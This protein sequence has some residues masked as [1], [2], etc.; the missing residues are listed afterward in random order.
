[1]FS[2]KTNY[3][4]KL[5]EKKHN[6]RNKLNSLL[7]S[8]S[9][10]Q[11]IFETLKLQKLNELKNKT[12]RV[13]QIM[14]AIGE[15]FKIKNK[16]LKMIKADLISQNLTKINYKRSLLISKKLKDLDKLNEEFDEEFINRKYEHREYKGNN[17]DS[18]SDDFY[19]NSIS[20]H[21][22]NNNELD[23]TSEQRRIFKILFIKNEENDNKPFSDY[24]K[25]K[26]LKELKSNIEYVCGIKL[27]EENS[28]NKTQ[29][30]TKSANKES[31]Y[32]IPKR[33]P[34]FI[35]EKNKN[36]SF[37]PS[38]KYDKSKIFFERN[39]DKS[40]SKEDK[41]K[42][43]I[44]YNL[45]NY[46]SNNLH[47]NKNFFM[48]KNDISIIPIKKRKISETNKF[49]INEQEKLPIINRE[50]NDENKNKTLNIP[51]TPTKL[52]INNFSYNN[53]RNNSKI[54]IKNLKTENNITEQ[55][56]I[57]SI[58]KN[59]LK[60][61]YT[62]NS[63]MKFGLNIISSHLDIYKKKSKKK[64]EENEIDIAKI[65]KELN[66]NLVN[67]IIRES[68]I[69]VKNEKKMEKKI[70]KEDANIL[71]KI[72]NTVLQEDRLANKNRVYNSNSLNSKLKKIMERRI[73]T[74]NAMKLNEQQEP[75]DDKIAMLKLFKGDNPNFFN[76]K[77]L[78]NLIKRYKT[79]KVK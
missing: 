20:Q 12:R 78:S 42:Q 38:L 79:M 37:T 58:L 26:Q 2:N 69:L 61:S 30:K 64:Q 28:N 32:F 33:S 73:K 67:P 49:E 60:D 65:R 45:Q 11:I 29:A 35:R 13:S 16:N 57:S 56:N 17:Y 39:Y 19:D 27:D 68:D 48:D 41:S 34:C 59:L 70:R 6:S 55:K 50:E 3:K 36:D 9:N 21:N 47:R 15:S 14:D 25:N 4:I 76:M 31:H 1:M 77:H 75:E 8:T 74:N 51:N 40:K 44:N 63:D 5:K 10:K 18:S 22:D 66:L 72:V 62:L 54:F 24:K 7:S 71:R 46:I 23:F 43:Y 53:K 52:R